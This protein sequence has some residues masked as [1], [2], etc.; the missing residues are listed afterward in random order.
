MWVVWEWSFSMRR[1]RL[2]N[3]AIAPT[4]LSEIAFLYFCSGKTKTSLTE[5]ETLSRTNNSHYPR[6]HLDSQERPCALSR[7]PTHSRQ[8]TYANTSQN[9]QHGKT[10]LLTAPSTVHLTTCFLPD[11]QHHRFSV[12]ASLPLS[13]SQ[14]FMN[15]QF[16]TL[17]H[18]RFTLSIGFQCFLYFIQNSVT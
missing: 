8:L 14:R 2:V 15:I 7:V 6:C 3:S 17:Y 4:S 13:P 5:I 11:S 16:F 9:T 10:T 1:H 12:K 18:Y